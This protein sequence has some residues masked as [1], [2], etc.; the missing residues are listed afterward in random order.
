MEETGEEFFL[1]MTLETDDRHFNISAVQ[2]QTRD[3]R[4]RERGLSL[5]IDK[6]KVLIAIIC[7]GHSNTTAVGRSVKRGER[8]KL[9]IPIFHIWQMSVREAKF[10]ICM[11]SDSFSHF[12]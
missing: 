5:V 9:Q 3:R 1:P 7:A 12:S 2:I 6:K 11:I 4:Q 8:K 10:Q